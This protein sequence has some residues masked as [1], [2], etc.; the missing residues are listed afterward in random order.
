MVLVTETF[1]DR[2][3]QSAEVD[4]TSSLRSRLITN[5]AMNGPGGG[6]MVL[7]AVLMFASKSAQSFPFTQQ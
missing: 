7:R 2:D 3:Q 6:P 1:L 4:L 5:S